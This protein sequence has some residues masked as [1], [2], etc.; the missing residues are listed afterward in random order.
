MREACT[1][2][3]VAP[4]LQSSNRLRGETETY[5]DFQLKNC[6]SGS[7]CCPWWWWWWWCSCCCCFHG[8]V[9][10]I[11]ALLSLLRYTTRYPFM[12]ALSCW[13]YRDLG[14]GCLS[15]VFVTVLFLVSIL[16]FHPRD[17]NFVWSQSE[18]ENIQVYISRMNQ[19]TRQIKS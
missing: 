16:I 4:K 2:L 19:G 8:G 6:P 13:L 14:G 5:F 11:S 7:Y 10:Y 18:T 1:L 15:K 12:E 9:T 17:T 3:A